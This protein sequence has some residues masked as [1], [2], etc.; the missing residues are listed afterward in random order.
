MPGDSD[1]RMIYLYADGASRGNPGAASYGAVIYDSQ[2]NVLA[3]LGEN[4]GIR[5]NN[6]AEYQGVIAGLRYVQEA[7]L[8]PAITIRMDS[9]LVIEQLSGRWK[10]KHPEMRE[11]VLE[12]SK[13]LRGLD[14][15]LEWIPREQ[16]S[17]ADALGNKALDQGDFSTVSN[18]K[19]ELA[20]IQPKSI[21][22]P[23]QFTEPTTIIVVR[24]GHTIMTEGN[25]ISGSNG[26]DPSLSDL[27]FEEARAAASAIGDLLDRF[28]LNSP[29]KIY[30]SPQLRTSQTAAVIAEELKLELIP[31]KRIREIGFGD[32]EGFSM[33]QIE[34]SESQEIAAWRGS[35]SAKP[36]GGESVLELEARVGSA[37]DEIVLQNSGASVVM[38]TH[39][40]PAR[41]VA[42]RALKSDPETNWALQF[43]PA[44][45]SVYRFFGSGLSETFAINSVSHLPR[46]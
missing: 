16:N 28:G 20:A 42:R 37:L 5:T 26:E 7:N 1:S 24:H 23:R 30:H 3:E 25:L 31:E 12:A 43:S 44:S 46:H 17:H 34:A 27:G 41:A 9:K 4:L 6:Y 11:L 38:V 8:G 32:W 39:M 13:L 29:T 33:D 36:P 2:M 19:F 40:M 35:L 15:T 10:V 45:V 14:A 18:S 22:A 21:R